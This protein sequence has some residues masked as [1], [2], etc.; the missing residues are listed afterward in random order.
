M[1]CELILAGLLPAEEHAAGVF[2][3][4]RLPALELLLARGRQSTHAS[5][6]LERWLADS[7]DCDADAEIPVGALSVAGLG[8]EAGDAV[9]MRADPVHLKLKRDGLVLVPAAAFGVQLT[10]AAALAETLNKHFAGEL[11]F[12]PLQ[13]ERWCVQVGNLDAT[14]LR[15][16]TPAE[17]A[18]K[19]VNHHLPS[20]TTARRWHSLLN[21]IQMALHEHPVNEAREAH[22]EPP[23]N[24]VWLWGAGRLP[25]VASAPW[26]SVTSDD[27]LAAGFAQIAEVR[28]RPLPANAADWLD[29]LPEDGRQLVVLDSLRMPF[30]LGDFDA[31][32]ARIVEIEERW[33]APLIT[34][35]RS[36][37][38]GMLSVCVPDGAELR[39]FESTRNDLRRF[40]RRAKPVSAFL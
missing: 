19:D 29:R 32:R 22:G 20:G 7:F 26:Q 39:S 6:S 13:A 24:S 17:V 5:V 9:W 11:I 18:G 28:H 25:G 3:D 23:V 12:H 27:P 1:H 33:C 37:R 31:W 15:C 34:A 30:A 36:G 16:E 14:G 2:D 40:W 8:A 38:I 35:L 21:E 4:L 10:E